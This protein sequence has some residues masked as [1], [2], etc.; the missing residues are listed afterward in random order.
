MLIFIC[1]LFYKSRWHYCRGSDIEKLVVKGRKTNTAA[2]Y[3]L[4]HLTANRVK[5][6]CP[7]PPLAERNRQALQPSFSGG[8]IA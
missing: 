6:D 4:Y 5:R 8:S 3:C 7:R 2:A 1:R